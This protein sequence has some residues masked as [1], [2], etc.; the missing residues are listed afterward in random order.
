[1]N[2]TVTGTL[3]RFTNYQ[4]NHMTEADNV[5]QGLEMLSET[6]PELK[7][8]LFEA[9]GTVRSIHRLFLNGEQIQE[10]ALLNRV[11]PNDRLDIITAIAGG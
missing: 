3:Q 6:Y 7:K 11:G 5:A 2:I 10:D 4:R 1:M 9:D 8:I